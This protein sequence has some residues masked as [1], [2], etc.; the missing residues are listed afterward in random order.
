[1]IPNISKSCSSNISFVHYNVQSF[2][3]KKDILYAELHHFDVV[4]FSETWL[5]NNINDKDI[6][7][8]NYHAPFRKDRSTD[9]HGGIL[10]YVSDKLFAKRRFDLEIP[11]IE[12]I[13]LEI[14]TKN[15]SILF[16]TFYRPPNSTANILTQ[17]ENS[18]GIATDVKYDAIVITGDFNLY[19]L[20]TTTSCKVN[21]I[22][23]QYG[24]SQMVKDYAFYR[25]FVIL[26]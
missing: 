23:Q 20:K 26:D 10:I 12:C 14:K 6:L 9:A 18:I 1:M 16:S 4:A 15:K 7:F 21:G 8:S 24:I 25:E 5:T 3:N 11:C 17:Y 19:M 2:F 13:W 22:T